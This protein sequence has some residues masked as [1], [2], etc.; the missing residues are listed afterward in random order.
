MLIVRTRSCTSSELTYMSTYHGTICSLCNSSISYHVNPCFN[1][2][3]HVSGIGASSYDTVSCFPRYQFNPLI[4]KMSYGATIGMLAPWSMQV[5]HA[6]AWYNLGVDHHGCTIAACVFSPSVA[7]TIRIPYYNDSGISTVT[8]TMVPPISCLHD[9]RCAPWYTA[10]YH[11]DTMI[12]YETM[13]HFLSP[14]YYR[15]L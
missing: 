14:W 9:G 3:R 2:S 10:L 8:F 12:S 1:W 4:S 13:V 5:Y 15:G 6:A 7:A 11:G